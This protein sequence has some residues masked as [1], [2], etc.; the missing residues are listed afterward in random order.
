MPQ[1][2]PEIRNLGEF[3]DKTFMVCIGAMKCATSWVHAYLDT[4]DGVTVS[5]LKEVHFF[6]SKFSAYALGDMDDFAIKR[7]G[8][9]MDRSGQA[10]QNLLLS[11]DF[12]ASVD[13]MQMIYDDTAYFAHFARL[14]GP[15]TRTFC[16]VT[17]AYSVLGPDGFGYMR[18]FFATQSI[19][20]KLVYILRDPVDRLW[21]QLRHLQEINPDGRIA[22]RWAE[23]IGS[24]AIMAR[25]DY[26]GTIVDLEMTFPAE[27]VLYLFYED[28]FEEATLQH[29]CDFVGVP[30]QAGN[31]EER[32]N[33]T[34]IE[35]KLP[36]EARRTF[37]N[38]LA[39]QY[40]F[41]RERFG[42]RVPAEWLA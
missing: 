27:N 38:V 13:R 12:Q 25:A 7:V 6:D 22:E 41:C 35:M 18:D 10:T 40:A 17:P 26:A 16:D 20:L 34:R 37:L 24:P 39:S 8:L 11:T 9:H 33:R 32:R 2:P 21:S 3:D 15:E 1:L 28:L 36:D 4:L 42:A 30:Y 23:A 31:T 19:H 5:P 29:L 14:A